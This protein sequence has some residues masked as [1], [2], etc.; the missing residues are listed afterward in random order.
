MPNIIC[1]S[2]RP[3][4]KLQVLFSLMSRLGTERSKVCF[5]HVCA[6]MSNTNAENVV[7][8]ACEECRRRKIKCDSANTNSWPCTP[9]TRN[10]VECVRAQSSADAEA[11]AMQP[12]H[13]RPAAASYGIAG[14]FN[15]ATPQYHVP[16]GGNNTIAFHQAPRYQS[17]IDGNAT[18]LNT[19]STP[20]RSMPQYM[21][22]GGIVSPQTPGTVTSYT[23]SSHSVQGDHT[24]TNPDELLS[25]FSSLSIGQNAVGQ[26]KWQDCLLIA[27]SY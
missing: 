14:S 23:M 9:C 18:H 12:S 3:D 4:H 15:Y 7:Q 11:T 6:R 1:V 5:Y 26:S 22:H 25:G 10:Q 21:D 24:S 19:F 16:Y 27:E 2:S 13:A 20:H 17:V 8:R